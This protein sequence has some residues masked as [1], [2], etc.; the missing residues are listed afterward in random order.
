[1]YNQNYYG[2]TKKVRNVVSLIADS[3]RMRDV[4]IHNFMINQQLFVYFN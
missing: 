3:L 1:M 2:P 4:D